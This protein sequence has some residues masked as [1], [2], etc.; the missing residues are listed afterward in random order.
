MG[1][2][3]WLLLVNT[4]IYFPLSV[5]FFFY[6]ALLF[7]TLPCLWSSIILHLNRINVARN[8]ALLFLLSPIDDSPDSNKHWSIL[9]A[10]NSNCIAVRNESGRKGLCLLQQAVCWCWDQLLGWTVGLM[11]TFRSAD[12]LPHQTPVTAVTQ[13]GVG[14]TQGKMK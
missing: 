5:I 6:V 12:H 1:L 11:R 4:C 9:S 14:D 10:Q 3:C 8:D 2:S 13:W 7:F